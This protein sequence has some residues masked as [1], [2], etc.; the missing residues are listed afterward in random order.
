MRCAFCLLAPLLVISY[1]YAQWS[2]WFSRIELQTVWKRPLISDPIDLVKKDPI[3]WV[4]P[5][6]DLIIK[7]GEADL[8]L[9]LNLYTIPEIPSKPYQFDLRIKVRAQGRVTGG[10][11]Q[12][13][14]I[15]DKH[16]TTDEPFSKEGTAYWSSYGQGRLEYGL[17]RVRLVAEEELRIIIDILVQDDY[18]R[19][20]MPRLKLVGK[21]DIAKPGPTMIFRG[22]LREGGYWTSICLVIMLAWFSWPL[23]LSL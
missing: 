4:V 20:A 23:K 11:W 22:I 14:L 3:E 21:Y 17:G 2:D 15:R 18:F 1:L 12:D 10:E 9:S 16:F 8:A 5:K 13:R 19:W 7:E 6:E